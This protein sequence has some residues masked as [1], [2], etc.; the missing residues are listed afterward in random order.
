MNSSLALPFSSWRET[1]SSEWAGCV[2]CAAHRSV[3]QAAWVTHAAARCSQHL[4]HA[5]CLK[6]AA[7]PHTY[8]GVFSVCVHAQHVIL[9][10]C[11]VNTTT[12]LTCAHAM[13][14]SVR[15]PT[16]TRTRDKGVR[17]RQDGDPS[18]RARHHHTQPS[19]QARREG[20][21]HWNMRCACAK[22][23]T[24]VRGF[25]IHPSSE[26]GCAHTCSL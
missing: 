6:C 17:A 26:L 10:K 4:A 2:A 16:H 5:L 11:S 18:Q 3:Y 25:Q 12:R 20:G 23:S 7:H 1:P 14:I 22:I 9:K 15:I 13:T 24:M 8:I 19:P 21:V